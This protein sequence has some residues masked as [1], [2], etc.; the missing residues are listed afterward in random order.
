MLVAHLLR[1]QPPQAPGFSARFPGMAGVASSLL[2]QLG[3]SGRSPEEMIPSA[4]AVGLGGR[5]V[6]R[7]GI[8]PRA[9]AHRLSLLCG[10][11]WDCPTGPTPSARRCW[12]LKRWARPLALYGFTS[13]T[14]AQQRLVEALAR[15]T[16]VL[17]ILDYEGSRGRE[18]T[19]Q[20]EFEYWRGLAGPRVEEFPAK[21]DYMSEPVAYL[22]RHFLDD[23]QPK[24]PPPP[25]W[26]GGEKGGVRFLLASG[27]RNEAELAA[28]EVAG[29]L[30]E[31]LSPGRYRY[32]RAQYEDVGQ[33][34]GRCVRLVRHPL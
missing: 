22:E 7:S 19:T 9:A 20:D 33:A 1:E 3:D 11:G 2:Q 26:E 27:Q 13:F 12:P 8:R 21:S 29:L 5:R 14:F 28:Q 17:L 34:L 24:E 31:G 25:A 23:A 30:A 16:E 32:R 4:D 15:V 18:L 6:G 10:T